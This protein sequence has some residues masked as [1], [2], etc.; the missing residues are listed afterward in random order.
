[1]IANSVTELIGKTPIMRLNKLAGPEAAEVLLKLEF[2]NPGGSIKDRIGTAM[3]LDAEAKGLIK[4]GGTIVEPTSGNTGIGLAVAAAARGYRLVIVM[5]DSMSAERRQMLKAYGADLVLTPGDQGM[6]GA[7]RKAEELVRENRGWFMPNQFANPSNPEI[8]YRTTG[9]EIWQ[10]VEGRLDYF[11]AGVGTGGTLT[12]TARYLKERTPELKVIAI[13]PK[14]SPVLSGGQPGLHLIQ[15]IGPG[16]VPE[17]LDMSLVDEVVQ[18]SDE[19]AYR[20]TRR[21]AREEGLL[22]GIS[23]GAAVWAALEIAGRLGSGHRI[24]A[25]APDTGER[26]LSTGVFD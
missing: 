18:V 21:L 8:H 25:I 4:P 19:D 3:I 10:A 20:I 23:S 26:Y 9:P 13:E 11:V 5:P 7:V 12:G 17:V 14:N 15:G 16:F 24:L 6:A 1:M 22:V 2:F